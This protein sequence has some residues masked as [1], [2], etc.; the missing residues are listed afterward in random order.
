MLRNILIVV[1]ICACFNIEAK[2]FTA[3]TISFLALGDSYT[4]GQSVDSTLRWPVQLGDSL[5]SKG[6]TVDGFQ[7]RAVT[8][9]TTTSLLNSLTSDQITNSYSSVA[10][11][12]GVNN[13]FQ[14][15]PESIYIV[16]FQQLLDS[17]IQYCTA[18]KEG[19]FVVS[20]PDYGYTP[21]GEPNQT[22]ISMQTDR[23]NFIGD[24]ISVANGIEFIN[25]T[26]ISRQ[27]TSDP[28]LAA[29]DRLHPSGKQYSLWV[30]RILQNTVESTATRSAL[31]VPFPAKKVGGNLWRFE[32]VLTVNVLSWNGQVLYQKGVVK[33]EVIDL[34]GING[35]ILNVFS[36]SEQWS[37]VLQRSGK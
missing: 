28:E 19:V 22:S 21:Y 27:W 11:L 18:G 15:R 7:I 9:W 16:D 24:S 10:L 8:G 26:D 37:K 4:I 14:G 6:K 25:I 12:I 13:F 33:G 34:S 29:Q 5:K 36:A 20:I 32:R 3:D 35:S 2:E 23:Y 30:N 17:A 1:F 31:S